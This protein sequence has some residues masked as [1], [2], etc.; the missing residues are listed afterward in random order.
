MTRVAQIIV[1][2]ACCLIAVSLLPALAQMRAEE[3]D[4]PQDVTDLISRRASC[5]DYIVRG[6]LDPA[7]ASGIAPVLITLR[8][9]DVVADENALRDRYG[10]DP[11]IIAALD[12]KWV[13]VVRRVPVPQSTN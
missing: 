12:H 9:S 11:H 6:Q 2:I 1:A 5:N 10:R 3:T 4:L 7:F 13:K 8:C